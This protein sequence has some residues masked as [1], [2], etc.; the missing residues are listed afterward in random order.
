MPKRR[1]LTLKRL[2]DIII[3]SHGN[4]MEKTLRA[5]GVSG[6]GVRYVVTT[7]D[8]LG[9]TARAGPRKQRVLAVPLAEA[10]RR[11][12][13]RELPPPKARVV[14]CAYETGAV[15]VLRV[16]HDP[17]GLFRQGAEFP[18]DQVL[19]RKWRKDAPGQWEA[20]TRFQRVYNG[21]LAGV[22]V[23]DGERVRPVGE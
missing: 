2:A 3:A 18:E 6:D 20:G 9:L 23:Y 15:N 1:N 22:Y 12:G 19:P 13:D 5:C 16:L 8:D 21:E 14:T 7:L 17:A 4:L 11:V 10:V